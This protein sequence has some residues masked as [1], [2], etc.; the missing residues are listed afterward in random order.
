MNAAVE[1]H[2]SECAVCAAF[3]DKQRAID[4]QLGAVLV[5]PELSSVF[6]SRLRRRIAQDKM[7]WWRDALPDM[8]H[9]TSLGVATLVSAVLLPFDISLT[10][11]TG[12]AIALL[13]Y[14]GF[15]AL[16]DVFED[17]DAQAA[18]VFRRAPPT[19]MTNSS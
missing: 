4:V 11:G 10:L 16:R 9:F 7:R 3:A 17:G 1:A 2:I 8:V 13:S 12:A 5:C 18:L 6:R 19:L 15:T 14:V